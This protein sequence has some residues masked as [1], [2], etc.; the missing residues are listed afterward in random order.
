[1][2]WENKDI[3]MGA[4]KLSFDSWISY[5]CGHAEEKVGLESFFFF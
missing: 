2:F 5:S 4:I 3:V 1:M